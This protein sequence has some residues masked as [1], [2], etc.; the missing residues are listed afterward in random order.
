MA[1]GNLRKNVKAAGIFLASH[2]F[3]LVFRMT[4]FFAEKIVLLKA[5]TK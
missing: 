2:A 5:K 4:L 3:V 1:L